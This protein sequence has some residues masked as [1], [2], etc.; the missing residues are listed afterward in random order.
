VVLVSSLHVTSVSAST[1]AGNKPLSTD[2]PKARSMRTERGVS[3]AVSR[4][5]V[6]ST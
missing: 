6:P 2:R 3:H 1:Y 5:S 4:V